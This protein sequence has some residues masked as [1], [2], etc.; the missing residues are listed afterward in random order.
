[1]LYCHPP[2]VVENMDLQHGSDFAATFADSQ[3]SIWR[4]DTFNHQQQAIPDQCLKA[5]GVHHLQDEVRRPHRPLRVPQSLSPPY[6]D[7]H[8]SFADLQ[9]RTPS[10]IKKIIP[11]SPP[12]H[13]FQQ[14]QPGPN[15]TLLPHL[16]SGLSDQRGSC[17]VKITHLLNPIEEEDPTKRG[18][19]PKS[20]LATTVGIPGL[21]KPDV[22]ILT[23]AKSSPP[24]H[25]LLE[26]PY[27]REQNCERRG[28]DATPPHPASLGD[29]TSIY[30]SSCKQTNRTEPAHTPFIEF[31][32]QPQSSLSNPFP[33]SGHASVFSQTTFDP[34]VFEVPSSSSTAQSQYRMMMLDTAQG[35]IQVPVDVQASSRVAKEK[36]KR[37]ATASHKFRQRRKEREQEVSGHIS[38][39][40]AHIRMMAE[41]VDYYRQERDYFRNVALSNCIPIQ[42]RPLSPRRR[43]QPGMVE[44]HS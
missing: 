18:K 38:R 16:P 11:I 41:E 42:P 24:H 29:S 25:M 26:A 36:R 30:H 17:P 5:Q 28:N 7:D 4:N 33:S 35:P 10:P 13:V 37:N 15:A 12:E 43:C 3:L 1:M 23:L 20:S 40:E 39:L 6:H 27:Y 44:H 34:N 31:T 8:A 9:T 19:V 14:T 32:G 21:T 22:P 2:P